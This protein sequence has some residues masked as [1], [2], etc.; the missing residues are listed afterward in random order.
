MEQNYERMMQN[1]NSM[2]EVRNITKRSSEF[3]DHFHDSMKPVL[4]E[5]MKRFESMNLKDIPFKCKPGLD[6]KR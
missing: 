6:D 3:Q 5:L 1:K 4:E 2:T